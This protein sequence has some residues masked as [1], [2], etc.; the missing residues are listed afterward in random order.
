M[1]QIAIIGLGRFGQQ[2]LMGCLGD[3]GLVRQ[4]QNGGFSN[5]DYF[6]TRQHLQVHLG[7]LAV[8]NKLV[9]E[10]CAADFGS[11]TVSS[12]VY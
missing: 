1:R 2:G 9:Q 8:A 5:L 6:R 7:E 10:F 4:I 12:G 3:E 11:K